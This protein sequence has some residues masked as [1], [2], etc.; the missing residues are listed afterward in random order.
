MN[1]ESYEEKATRVAEI[2][3]KEREGTTGYD[4]L[5]SFGASIDP[6]YWEAYRYN[7]WGFFTPQNK[8][9]LDHMTREM[10][11]CGVLSFRDRPG[12][13]VHA[14]NALKEGATLN[15]LLEVFEV[16]LF[17]GG[18][19]SRMVG[20][21]TLKRIVDEDPSLV[22]E[23]RP[24]R[25][26]AEEVARNVP[27]KET[28]EEKIKRVTET[29]EKAN[30]YVDE[31][32]SFG[33]ELDPDYF[34]IYSRMHWSFFEEKEGFLTPIQREL[35][36]MAVFAFR[37]FREELYFHSKKALRL[38]ASMEQLLECFQVCVP[39]GGI[40]LLHEGLRTLKKINDE[41]E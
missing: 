17:P 33:V 34:D 40:A 19:P 29:I 31:A 24:W 9:H 38:G 26:D 28:R 4:N 41:A 7:G 2:F 36:V 15:Q 37:G 22:V 3:R 8:R 30:G 18:G 13:Y 1:S 16:A 35:I 25:F 12:V 6:D 10:I 5:L 32:I 27:E 14:K 11:V 39:P 23:K 20:L 21:E